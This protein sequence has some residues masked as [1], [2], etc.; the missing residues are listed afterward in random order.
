LILFFLWLVVFRGLQIWWAAWIPP[1]LAVPV[2]ILCLRTAY[3]LAVT[4]KTL[5]TLIAT[6][7]T[8]MLDNQIKVLTEAR[9]KGTKVEPPT[10]M[11][12][13]VNKA[14]H[15]Y[16]DDRMHT[17][18]QRE[19]M[20][21]FSIALVMAIVASGW[22]WGLVGVA[23]LR[24]DA[25][26]LDAYDY[27]QTGSLTEALTWAWGCMTTAISSPGR[28]AS[29]WRK[30]THALILATGVFQLT[31]LLACFSIMTSAETARTVLEA[32]KL[33]KGTRD[34]LDHTRAM[35]TSVIDAEAVVVEDGKPVV[36]DAGTSATQSSQ[37]GETL[38]APP[39]G[40][41]SIDRS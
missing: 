33:F 11:Y 31:F 27:F 30:V 25:H 4:P 35:E 7:C 28:L 39:T 6:A 23:I 17:V 15:R 14:L 20:A 32:T 36:N 8:T 26:A 41:G 22:F 37:L 5:V 13:I 16:S 19:A 21:V 24:T 2:W 18:V 38:G 40:S 29:T 34:K 10:M 1:V 9:T 12:N 3:R